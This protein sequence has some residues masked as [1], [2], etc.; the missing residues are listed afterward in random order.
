VH[1][2]IS[3]AA[4]VVATIMLCSC[5]RNVLVNNTR[6]DDYFSGEKVDAKQLRVSCLHPHVKLRQSTGRKSCITLDLG[7]CFVTIALLYCAQSGG[8]IIN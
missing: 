7:F 8:C 4:A 6:S 1:D 2:S 3:R 5:G